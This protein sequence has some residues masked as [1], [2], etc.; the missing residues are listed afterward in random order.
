MMT[1]HGG[2][3]VLTS[4]VLIVIAIYFMNDGSDKN[5]TQPEVFKENRG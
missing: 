2:I 1:K 5:K 3:I 4:V